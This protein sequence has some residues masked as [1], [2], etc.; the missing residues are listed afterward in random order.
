MLMTDSLE[1]RDQLRSVIKKARHQFQLL[2]KFAAITF[3]TNSRSR[4]S[5]SIEQRERSKIS[6]QD[7][8]AETSIFVEEER[9]IMTQIAKEYF[10]NRKR[11]NVHTAIYYEIMMHEYK[12]SSNC[13]VLI[14]E[15][16][17]RYLSI[18]SILSYS[19]IA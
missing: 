9:R 10:N 8:R 11:S 17:H 1:Q 16:K 15:D 4:Q 12:I 13:N 14:E 5:T 6:D 3:N 7:E 19:R 2:L 18:V